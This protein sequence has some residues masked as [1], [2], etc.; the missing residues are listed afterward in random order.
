MT[1]YYK[2]GDFKDFLIALLDNKI[3]DAILV[4]MKGLTEN[5]Y[6]PFLIK[7]RELL[8][9]SEPISPVMAVNSARVV[10]Q[11]TFKGDFLFKVAVVL[12][13]CEILAFRELIKLNQINSK[14]II[15]ICFDCNGINSL[16][17][18]ENRR[19]ICEIC[20]NFT[21]EH[22]DIKIFSLGL[23]ESIISTEMDL[24]ELK[25]EEVN[26]DNKKREEFLNKKLAES[27]EK[28]K[29]KLSQVK[30][31]FNDF[32]KNCIVCKNCMRVCP[33]C[34]CQECFFDSPALNGN[35]ITY[36]M[37]A[38]RMSGLVF[39]ENKLLFHLGRMNH[40]S[41]SC[42]GC[43]ACEDAC[44]AEIPVAQMFAAAGDE[45]KSLFDYQP[46]GN[47]EE[48]IP[49]TCY[50]HDELHSFEQPYRETRKN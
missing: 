21:P 5:T 9:N 27:R 12:K 37:R 29:E 42:V 23:S 38:S 8:K 11:L 13:P 6:S 48:K 19:E 46:G 34:F 33:I 3:V 36:S 25:L 1:N 7:D 4:P 47:L 22:S 32:L 41:V 18:I 24:K 49:F 45:L 43:G 30:A 17:D 31:E 40:M 16:K 50:E 26:F 39:P 28:R 20:T 15:T 14:N 10:S 44:P 35:S 2:L